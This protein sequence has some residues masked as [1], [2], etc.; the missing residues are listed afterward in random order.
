MGWNYLVLLYIADFDPHILTQWSCNVINNFP[1]LNSSC[2]SLSS[3][4]V[5]SNCRIKL[6]SGVTWPIE[7][8]SADIIQWIFP[9]SWLQILYRSS[10]RTRYFVSSNSNLWSPQCC[11]QYHVKLEYNIMAHSCRRNVV[12]M[13]ALIWINVWWLVLIN[14]T[15]WWADGGED[16]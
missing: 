6:Q 2:F 12:L 11:M 16:V 9:I 10:M 14:G 15:I 1:C 5:L 4:N 13:H 8:C 3:G 7:Q